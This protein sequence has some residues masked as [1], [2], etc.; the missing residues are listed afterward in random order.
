MKLRFTGGKHIYSYNMCKK[1]DFLNVYY[2]EKT[3]EIIT[4]IVKRDEKTLFFVSSK[5]NGK[6]IYQEFEKAKISAAF[7]TADNKD[8]EK[9][10]EIIRNLTNFYKFQERVLVAT[11]VLDVG[12]NIKDE[13]VV[14]VVI[15]AY[16]RDTFLQMLGR[17]RQ[18]NESPGFNLFIRK[19][20]V[21]DFNLQIADL[22]KKLN[23]FQ[24][25]SVMHPETFTSTVSA[26]ILSS[27]ETELLKHCTYFNEA[28]QINR[29]ARYQDNILYSNLMDIVRELRKDPDYSLKKQ[30][31]WV[32][33]EEE[34]AYEN[35]ISEDVK[36]IKVSDTARKLKE[37]SKDL[38]EE[39]DFKEIQ[40][41]CEKAKLL[42]RDVDAKF[43]RKS[44]PLSIKKF[45][46]FM[47]IYD[48]SLEIQIIKY[49]R[50]Q[51]YKVVCDDNSTCHGKEG[52]Q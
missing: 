42:I 25:I 28:Y 45:N 8:S 6:K 3:D 27:N 21:S 35:F 33:K 13:D 43:V 29:L 2:Y 23:F 37:L 18:T 12:V 24:K 49:S 5:E 26:I 48:I 30:L 40:K 14:N 20:K 7:I 17:I 15:E 41:F 31:S 22:E 32:G 16:D 38:Q 19:W 50:P 9:G 47:K 10:K 34:F 39:V 51:K 36:A 11:S 46:N 1:Y 52:S 4:H 44:S